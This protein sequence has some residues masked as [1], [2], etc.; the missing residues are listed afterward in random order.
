MAS[1]ANQEPW[2]AQE[3]LEESIHLARNIQT[4][5]DEHQQM[6]I[7]GLSSAALILSYDAHLAMIG[8][9]EAHPTNPDQ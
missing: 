7:A 9:L 3:T 1:R 5:Q 8:L 2:Q 6:P 4:F